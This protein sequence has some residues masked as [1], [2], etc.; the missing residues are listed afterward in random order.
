MIIIALL[1]LYK[2]QWAV[3]SKILNSGVLLS[4]LVHSLI[5]SC[6]WIRSLLFLRKDKSSWL[7]KLII[8]ENLSE[9]AVC[10]GLTT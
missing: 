8:S 9:R 3:V 6:L 2:W 7:Y 5:S 10:C 4:M 1:G